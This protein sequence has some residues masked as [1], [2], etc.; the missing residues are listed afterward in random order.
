MLQCMLEM[1]KMLTNTRKRVQ[2]RHNQ[3]QRH[4]KSRCNVLQCA[5]EMMKI[6]ARCAAWWLKCVANIHT[7]HQVNPGSYLLGIADTRN[8][9]AP[10]GHHKP[11]VKKE[12][13]L[14]DNSKQTLSTPAIA[15][16]VEHLTVDSADIRWSLVRFRVAGFSYMR[17]TLDRLFFGKYMFGGRLVDLFISIHSTV[18]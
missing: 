16:L 3:C 9:S 5:F 14:L 7:T 11:I 1:T 8:G 15:Q 18:A 12:H 17:R 4:W 2:R 13:H 6:V 10:G